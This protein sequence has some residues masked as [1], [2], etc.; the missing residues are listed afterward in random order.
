MRIAIIYNQP[1]PSYYDAA[2][3]QGAVLGILN[4]VVAVRKTLLKLGHS[5]ICLALALPLAAARE[6]LGRLEVDLVFNL[7]EGFCGYPETEADIPAILTELSLTYTGCPPTA[8]RLALDKAQTKAV[9][10]A[11]G[12]DTTDFQL[13]NATS[14][15]SFRLNYPCMVK[16]NGEDGSHGVSAESVVSD[17]LSLER[18]LAAVIQRYGGEEALVE[19]FIDG[20]EF[21]ATVVGNNE[22]TVLAVSEI[23]FSLPPDVPRILTFA[24]KWQEGSVYFRGTR[25][26]CPARIP[27]DERQRIAA[28]AEMA[29]R[30]TGCRGYARVDMRRDSNG[31]LAVIEVNPNPDISPDAGVA[32]QAQA[33]GLNYWK[34]IE[35]IMALA[36]EGKC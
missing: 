29:F 36:L 22:G 20:R 18:Q 32:L 13:L 14:L 12:L 23:A 5:V 9:L 17:F 1:V 24:S 33:S 4:E 34:F 31:R 6:K 19:E 7:F 10:R 8:L 2:G 27:E 16:P 26:I 21:N 11:A 30:F 25:A 3:E 15:S 28:A 35:K